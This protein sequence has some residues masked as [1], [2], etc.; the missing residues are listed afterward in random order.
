MTTDN[1]VINKATVGMTYEE[2]VQYY[3]KHPGYEALAGE[4]PE[5][6]REIILRLTGR[7]PWRKRRSDAR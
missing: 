2:R 5:M 1:P 3:M 4:P 6:T 7:D